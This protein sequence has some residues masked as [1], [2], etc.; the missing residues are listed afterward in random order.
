[1]RHDHTLVRRLYERVDTEM[2]EWVED[3]PHV[4]LGVHLGLARWY[5]LVVEYDSP[6][7]HKISETT[8]GRFLILDKSLI[9]GE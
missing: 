7:K 3:W 8:P 5:K 4:L 6:I 2:V 9:I 1:M